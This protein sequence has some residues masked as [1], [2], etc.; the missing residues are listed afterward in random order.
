MLE[1][2]EEFEML[3]VIVKELEA[4][5]DYC[6]FFLSVEYEYLCFSCCIRNG[7]LWNEVILILKYL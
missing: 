5:D 4:F 7:K 1:M 6:I 2:F 3:L